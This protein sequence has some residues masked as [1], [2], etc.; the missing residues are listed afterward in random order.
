MSQI[1]SYGYV[2]LTN[3]CRQSKK[4]GSKYLKRT[5]EQRYSL[6]CRKLNR[7]IYRMGEKFGYI[8]SN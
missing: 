4:S 3:E 8:P 6:K 1:A 5:Y 2:T 7:H